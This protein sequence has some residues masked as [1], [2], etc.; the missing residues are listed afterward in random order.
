MFLCK[1]TFALLAA[2]SLQSIPMPPEP[3]AGTLAVMAGHSS[4]SFPLDLG[5]KA[6][7]NED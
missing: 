5:V 6:S 1:S 3:L 2:E 4:L 7:Q